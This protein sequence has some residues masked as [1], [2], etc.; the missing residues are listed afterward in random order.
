M[1]FYF[2]RHSLYLS[3]LPLSHI[4]ILP[5]ISYPLKDSSL[6]IYLTIHDFGVFWKFEPYSLPSPAPELL[7]VSQIDHSHIQHATSLY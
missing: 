1:R 4:S 7:I 5:T 6:I 3:V 2:Q